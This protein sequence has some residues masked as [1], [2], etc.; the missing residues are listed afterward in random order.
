VNAPLAIELYD[1]DVMRA[2]ILPR[3]CEINK[4]RLQEAQRAKRVKKATPEQAVDVGTYAPCAT[5]PGVL[6]LN[7]ITGERA[8]AR[9]AKADALL[10]PWGRSR[11]SRNS[12]C[13]ALAHEFGAA[14][15]KIDRLITRGIRSKRIVSFHGGQM[16]LEQVRAFVA[17]IVRGGDPNG[18]RPKLSM[19][20][21]LKRDSSKPRAR[22]PRP[23]QRTSERPPPCTAVNPENPDRIG[24]R[25]AATE[26]EIPRDWIRWQVSKGRLERDENG[27]I[28]REAC[29]ELWQSTRDKKRRPQRF[30]C[31][32]SQIGGNVLIAEDGG[33]SCWT[34]TKRAQRAA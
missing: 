2:R 18:A 16:Y 6:A 15:E 9:M 1:C 31:G 33:R 3:Q 20:A 22:K 29:R 8:E 17:P 4:A 12:V 30:P 13:Q 32:H 10:H 14:P 21:S 28:S 24:I 5:C 7:G 27:H 34:C 25:T 19:K 11:A 26:L 23:D